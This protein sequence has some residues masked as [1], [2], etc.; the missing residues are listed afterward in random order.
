MVLLGITGPIGHGKSTLAT[1]L[2]DSDVSSVHLETGFLVAEVA[3]AL[4]QKLQSIPRADD[5]AG[6]NKWLHYLPEIAQELLHKEITFGSIRVQ[7][8]DIE[9][10]PVAY[11]KL[12]EYLDALKEQPQATQVIITSENKK[13]YRPFLQWLGGYLVLKVG[14]GI[15]YDELIRRCVGA[16]VELG[17]ISGVRFPSDATLVR[18]AHGKIMAIIRPASKEVDIQDPTER[19]RGTITAD[20]IVINNGSLDDLRGISHKILADIKTG[21]LPA[22]YIAKS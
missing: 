1:M 7:K 10:D 11:E 17:I 21:L 22:T 19:D 3:D 12:F 5:I 13:F 15:W 8:N 6:I 20:T 16:G 9:R 14:P 2:I 4:H 18:K